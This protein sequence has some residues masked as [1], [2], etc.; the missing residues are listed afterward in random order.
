VTLAPS[1]ISPSYKDPKAVD[2]SAVLTFPSGAKL[3][4]DGRNSRREIVANGQYH[5]DIRSWGDGAAEQMMILPVAVLHG[6]LRTAEGTVLAP[7]PI[8]LTK[9]SHGVFMVSLAG[10]DVESTE[11]RIFTL[12]GMPMVT[13][14]SAPGD[15]TRVEWPMASAGGRNIA[16]GMY[17]AV[18]DQRNGQGTLQRSIL[19]AL[20]AP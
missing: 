17:L 11:V 16:I 3:A 19:K 12:T 15:P 13:L 20:V 5:I 18:V 6:D 14:S 4:W 7:N 10:P 2:G 8:R 1:V 9:D